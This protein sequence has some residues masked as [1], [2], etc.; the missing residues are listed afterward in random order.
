[1]F[2][3]ILPGKC[4]RRAG[5]T[6]TPGLLGGIYDG[7]SELVWAKSAADVMIARSFCAKPIAEV[8]KECESTGR[9]AETPERS[10]SGRKETL[11]SP[12]AP[13]RA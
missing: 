8:Q 2:A 9:G 12:T 13:E 6:D 4:S 7:I 1:V 10:S 11:N 5:L 3:P